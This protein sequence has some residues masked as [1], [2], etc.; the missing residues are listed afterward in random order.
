MIK[1]I[2]FRGELTD[3]SAKKEAL[4]IDECMSPVHIA[5]AAS[6]KLLVVADE[7]W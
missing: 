6:W 4:L 5:K 3:I 2:I 7:K 1:I